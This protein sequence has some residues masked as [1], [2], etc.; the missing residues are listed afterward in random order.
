MHFT[1]FDL[2]SI[3][4]IYRHCAIEKRVIFNT[5][6][7][8]KLIYKRQRINKSKRGFMQRLSSLCRLHRIRPRYF[9]SLQPPPFDK[10]EQ[11]QNTKMA[12][13]RKTSFPK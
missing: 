2:E 1:L 7:I 10:R 3:N 12:E 8:Y 9:I 5:Q 6:L 13:R 4:R 11:A